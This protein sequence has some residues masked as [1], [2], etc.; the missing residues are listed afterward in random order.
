MFTGE[1]RAHLVNDLIPFWDR[2]RDEKNGGFY[3]FMDAD[4]NLEREA[5]KG[6]ILNSRILWFFSN[7]AVYLKDERCLLDAKQAY[8]FLRDHLVDSRYGGVYW[9]V[10]AD[11][12]PADTLKHTYNQAFA[13]YGLSSYYEASGDRE[14]LQLAFTLANLVEEKMRDENGYLES[15]NRD[16]SPSDNEKL[17]EHGVN[18]YRTMN[19]LLHLLEAYTELYRVSKDSMIR[20]KICEMLDI[21]AEKVYNPELKRQECFFDADYHSL[22]DLHSYGH[23]IEASWLTERSLEV[24]DDPAYT[25]KILPILHAVRDCS[26]EKG[27]SGEYLFNE[28]DK[29]VQDKTA[30]WWVQAETVVAM[31]NAYQKSG[32]PDDLEC[33]EKVWAFIRRVLIDRASGGEW[34]SETDP[35]GTDHRRPM[36]SQ[37]KCP[38][39]NGR[40]CLEVLKRLDK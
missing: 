10:Q 7:C 28:C 31:V 11:G 2:L 16:F 36:V 9:S 5:K 3:G 6:G 26:M 25:A 1:I 32:N 21:V 13:I 14:A 17:S 39:H 20:G 12:T 40:M 29:G 18:A 35:D 22:T 37:W 38:Y 8:E 33:A 27:F 19:T 30:V 15:F 4:L 23:D 34:H 24:L